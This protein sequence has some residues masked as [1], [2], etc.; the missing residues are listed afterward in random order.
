LRGIESELDGGLVGGQPEVGEEVAN[1]LL[2]SVDDL[3]GR[4]LVDGGGHVGAEPLEAAA[5]LLEKVLGSELGL[6]GH[7]GALARGS[8]EEAGATAPATGS[9]PRI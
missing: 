6:V 9:Q 2:G 1:F 3:A 4:G 8:T 5:E 7:E